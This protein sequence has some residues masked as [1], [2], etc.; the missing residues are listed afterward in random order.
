MTFELVE[1]VAAKNETNKARISYPKYGRAMRPSLRVTLPHHVV[2][3]YDHDDN[4]RFVLMIGRDESSGKACIAPALDGNIRANMLKKSVG[5]VFGYV[6]T[7]GEIPRDAE[8]VE[9]SYDR[10]A[11]RFNLSLPSWWPK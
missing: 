2:D 11:K 5:F 6:P 9:A 10:I 7:L 1:T 4:A 8:M 3:D